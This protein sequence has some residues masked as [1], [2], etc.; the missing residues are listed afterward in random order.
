MEQ[1]FKTRSLGASTT[2]RRHPQGIAAEEQ[3]KIARVPPF[4]E[5]PPPLVTFKPPG[6]H[7]FG[8][9]EASSSSS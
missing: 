1:K 5:K 6:T 2:A 8:D 9:E 7:H 3:G 4:D